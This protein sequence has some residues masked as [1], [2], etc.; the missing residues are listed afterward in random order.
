MFDEA[1]ETLT[2]LQLGQVC[3]PASL[4]FYRASA[5][6]QLL[7]KSECLANVCCCCS[8]EAELPLRY[9]QVARLMQADISPPKR[10]RWTK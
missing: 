8:R 7:K 4:L 5:E 6:H 9:R 2:G 1:H 3:D 10:T